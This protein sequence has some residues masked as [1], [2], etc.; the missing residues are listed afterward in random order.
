M[1]PLC[2]L[3]KVKGC[4]VKEIRK[5]VLPSVSWLG[6][7]VAVN[8][9]VVAEAFSCN[10]VAPAGGVTMNV[11]L[12]V[13]VLTTLDCAELTVGVPMSLVAAAVTVVDCAK[14]SLVV[15]LTVKLPCVPGAYWP[16][17]VMLTE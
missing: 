15:T 5:G 4:V 7:A 6:W 9:P 2:P 3:N 16:S 8:P 1:L 11:K 14:P 10:V 12:L 17:G 13:Q